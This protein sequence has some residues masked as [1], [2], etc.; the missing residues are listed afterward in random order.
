M[1]HA[2]VDE[3]CPTVQWIQQLARDSLSE[4]AR[5]RDSERA[6][7][8]RMELRAEMQKVANFNKRRCLLAAEKQLTL[9]TVFGKWAAQLFLSF[10]DK[11]AMT[12][13]LRFQ[14]WAFTTEGPDPLEDINEGIHDAFADLGNGSALN[15]GIGVLSLIHI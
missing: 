8:R 4:F 6:E 11:T 10:R 12:D 14:E 5:W 15:V 3:F 2:A 7:S 9:N 1:F 13:Y